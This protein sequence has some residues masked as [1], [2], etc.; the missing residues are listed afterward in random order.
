MFIAFS[1]HHTITLWL[2]DIAKKI[3]ICDSSVSTKQP[4]GQNR[5]K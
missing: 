5:I 1:L 2:G 3:K 4:L